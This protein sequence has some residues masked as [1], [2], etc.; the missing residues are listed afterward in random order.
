V[1]PSDG[2]AES[3]KTLQDERG[4]ARVTAVVSRSLR[5]PAGFAWATRYWSVQGAGAGHQLAD[6]R[7]GAQKVPSQRA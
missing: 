3:V 4:V 2:A 6:Q 5:R 7:R 1:I